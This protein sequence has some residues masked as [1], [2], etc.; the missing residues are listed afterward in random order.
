M[1]K[2]LY[3]FFKFF[4]FFIFFGA[5]LISTPIYNQTGWW[6][7]AVLILLVL[8]GENH[9][10]NKLSKLKWQ[11]IR[12]RFPVIKELKSGDRVTITLKNGKVFSDF[13]FSYFNEFD[14][15]VSRNTLLDQ[16]LGSKDDMKW[17]KC[18]KI[19]AI[20]KLLD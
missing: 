10:D 8:L 19:S 1:L 14:I 15:I 13:T 3:W 4:K 17:I 12:D 20:E 5:I 18:S 2:V 6:G 16:V 9:F 11:N 7:I